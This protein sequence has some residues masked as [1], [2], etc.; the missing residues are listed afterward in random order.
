[1]C[2][3]GVYTYYEP[4]GSCLDKGIFLRYRLI[5]YFEEELYIDL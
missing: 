1:M 5:K 2:G 3:G 4:F